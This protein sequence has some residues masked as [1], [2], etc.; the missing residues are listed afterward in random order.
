MRK[1][2]KN[3]PINI[4]LVDDDVDERY[5]FKTAVEELTFVTTL[6]MVTNGA[7]LMNYLTVNSECLPD[8]ISSTL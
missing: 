7:S 4:L 8:V 6:N 2:Q 1:D 3:K 5:F